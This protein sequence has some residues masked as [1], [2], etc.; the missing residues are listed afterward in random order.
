MCFIQP[1]LEIGIL[2]IT[3]MKPVLKFIIFLLLT[4][5][6]FHISCKKERS[7]EVCEEKNKPPISIAGPDQVITLPTDSVSL[8]GSSSSDPDGK[9]SEW[10]WTKISGPASFN[11][12]NSS[13]AKQHLLRFN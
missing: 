1:G 2:N 12:N 9:I 3:I 11:M 4:G 10:L 13:A 8:N 5:V 7:C 6:L